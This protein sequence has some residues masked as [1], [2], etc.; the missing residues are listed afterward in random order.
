MVLS[1]SLRFKALVQESESAAAGGPLPTFPECSP[2]SQLGRLLMKG[3]TLFALSSLSFAPLAA[4]GVTTAAIRGT[5]TREGGA[6]IEGAAISL[7]N[8]PKG[9][10][11]RTVSTSSGRYTF[12]N[13]ETGGPYTIEIA[14]IGYEKTTK[15]GITL[16]LGQRYIQ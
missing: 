12:D 16:T 14:A 2:M 13:V 3:A 4:Q 15:T 8:V 9:T 6:P 7:I 1:K 5:V 10:R 11:L